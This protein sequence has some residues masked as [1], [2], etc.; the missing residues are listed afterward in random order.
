L[1]KFLI[2]LCVLSIVGTV[3][4]GC[5]PS[6]PASTASTVTVKDTE[7]DSEIAKVKSAITTLD[8]GKASKSALNDLAD[9]VSKLNTASSTDLSGYYT[10]TQVDSAISTAVNNAITNL[11][12]EKP[13]GTGTGTTTTSQTGSVQFTTNPV[14]IPQ[15]FSSS[16]GGSSTP[17]IMTI[18]N[19]S[20]TWQYVKPVINLNVASGQSSSMVNDI[21]VL[22]SGGSCT[23]TGQYTVAGGN[24]SF[25]P[26]NM[27]ATATPSIVIIPISGCN[28]SGEFQIGPGQQQAFN[29]QIQNLKT[30]NPILWNVNTSI[31]SRSM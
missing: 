15:I 24:F 17:W 10:K 27:N 16:T 12:N 8:E 22:I 29:V 28:G 30:P 26:T 3:G 25:S 19:Q 7:Q 9:R 2:V 23:L 6:K 13:W 14:S 18:S 4:L 21:T 5:L 20:S 11:K 1:K 31:S